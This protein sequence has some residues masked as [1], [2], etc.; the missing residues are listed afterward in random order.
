M[1][2]KCNIDGTQYTFNENAN[3]PLKR[4]L[5]ENIPAFPSNSSCTGAS[6]G[7]CLIIFN[8]SLRYSCL[9]PAFEANNATITTYEGFVKTRGFHDIERAYEHTGSQPCSICFKSK[10]LIIET[11]INRL[12]QKNLLL[13]KAS[14]RTKIQSLDKQLIESELNVIP[15]KCMEINE[16]EK[17]TNLAYVYRS[18]RSA[19]K[20]QIS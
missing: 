12:E 19:R 5:E 16:I 18:N 6:C 7:N 3:K 14:L 15:C 2:L 4:I 13:G 20:P 9:I 8:N 17:L 1:I 10:T 11:L